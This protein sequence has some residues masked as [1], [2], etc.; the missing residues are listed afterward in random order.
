MSKVSKQRVLEVLKDARA[1]VQTGWTQ[2]PYAVDRHGQAVYPKTHTAC[3]WCSWGALIAVAHPGKG[4]AW[5]AK[6]ELELELL[7]TRFGHLV[8]FNESMFTTKDNVLKLFNT[9][10][11]RL[12]EAVNDNNTEVQDT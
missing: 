4:E 5:A 10:I 9:T 3:K 8:D 12:T 7:G 11:N 6:G 1:K 2:G